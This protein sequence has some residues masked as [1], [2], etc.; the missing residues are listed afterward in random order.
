LARLARLIAEGA[1][2]PPIELEAPW[3]DIAKV[4]KD[5]YNRGVP[6]KAVLLL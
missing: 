1:V 5:F 2:R 4:A 6:G 3:T